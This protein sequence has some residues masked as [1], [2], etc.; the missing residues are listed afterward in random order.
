MKD[1]QECKRLI[2]MIRRTLPHSR[3]P[4]TTVTVNLMTAGMDIPG[5]RDARNRA[6]SMNWVLPMGDYQGGSP[7]MV[8]R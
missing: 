6:G 3:L 1:T 8:D 7:Y 2:G 4:F 5:H